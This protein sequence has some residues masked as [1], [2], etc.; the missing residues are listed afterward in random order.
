MKEERDF[1]PKRQK[2]DI[3]AQGQS[4]SFLLS[5]SPYHPGRDKLV[6]WFSI[7]DPI[8]NI[9]STDKTTTSKFL[10]NFEEDWG[11]GEEIIW[12]GWKSFHSFSLS[13]PDLKF[14]AV[15]ESREDPTSG[16]REVFRRCCC[17]SAVGQNSE[18]RGHF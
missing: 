4:R 14:L 7:K 3:L 9:F 12:H 18:V 11:R 10:S 1:P 16:G 13:R 17:G 15:F 8:F 6:F 2:C 5:F